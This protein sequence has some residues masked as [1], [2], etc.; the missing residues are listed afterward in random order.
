MYKFW[1]QLDPLSGLKLSNWLAAEVAARFAEATPE[2]APSDPVE[3]NAFLAALALYGL[4]ERGAGGGEQARG[5][6]RPEVTVV[7]DTRVHDESG[8]PVVDW[9]LPVELPIEV[10]LELAETGDVAAVV[11][12]N[13]VVIHAPGVVDLGRTT[14][15]ANGAQRR[16]LRGLYPR[17][18]IPDCPVRFDHCKVHHVVWWRHGGRTDLDNLLPVCF[19][20]HQ[21]IHHRG[22]V[23]ELAA[24]RTLI[25]TLPDGGRHVH[26][27]AGRGPRH[28]APSTRRSPGIVAS[29]P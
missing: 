27:A 2:G 3:R 19:R 25:V 7:V 13:G 21:V 10:L 15:L 5:S 16:V 20:H 1:G 14:R 11:V 28:E 4:V 22:W 26:R 23:V 29:R 17:C 12:R 9:G 8:G 24:D 18:A 6:G